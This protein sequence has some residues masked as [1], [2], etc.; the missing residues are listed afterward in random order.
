MK[1]KERR[2]FAVR[3]TKINNYNNVI[4]FIISLGIIII[5]NSSAVDRLNSCSRAV[6]FN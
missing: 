1:K 2:N 4:N 6:R 5:I 3:L